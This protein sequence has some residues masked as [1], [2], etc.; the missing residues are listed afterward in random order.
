MVSVGVGAMTDTGG[1]VETTNASDLY[2]MTEKGL[3]AVMLLGQQ[4][5]DDA[6]IHHDRGVQAQ[7]FGQHAGRR[8]Q[9]RRHENATRTG[10]YGQQLVPGQRAVK[11]YAFDGFCVGRGV[12]DQYPHPVLVCHA[13]EGA[14]GQRPVLGVLLPWLGAAYVDHIGPKWCRRRLHPC[15]I[16]CAWV[17][18]V[19]LADQRVWG[20]AGQDRAGITKTMQPHLAQRFVVAFV[21]VAVAGEPQIAGD[22]AESVPRSGQLSESSVAVECHQRRA[23]QRPPQWPAE[24]VGHVPYRAGT[25]Q[26]VVEAASRPALAERCADRVIL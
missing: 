17:G 19:R 22:A 1:V 16:D 9:H 5:A 10:D 12:D 7:R 2:Q 26:C 15:R 8:V 23:Y 25:G 20:L 24:R 6:S 3:C 14:P 11:R 21:A 13:G 18:E 4:A